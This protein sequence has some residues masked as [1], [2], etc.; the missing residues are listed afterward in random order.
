MRTAASA[1]AMRKVKLDPITIS[2]WISLAV[3]AFFWLI[4]FVF[5]VFTAF[6][7]R[8]EL[9]RGAAWYPPK[10]LFWGNFIDAWNTGKFSTYGVNSLIITLS[11]VPIG[12]FVSALAAFAFSRLR[13]RFQKVLFMIVIMGTM[14]PVQVALGPIFQIMLNA[15]LLST[16]IGILLPYIAFGIPYHV[17]LFNNFFKSIPRELDEAALIDG[18]SKFGLLWRIIIPLSLPIMAAVFILDFVSTWNEFAIALVILQSADAWTVPLG[19][20]AF[21]GQFSSNYGALNASIVLS[22]IPVVIVYLLFQRYFVSGLTAGAV[23]G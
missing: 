1:A 22:I 14:I 8:P 16:Y 5:I 2:L 13:F 9:I 15:K 18:C 21:R 4:P 11:K 17:F 3:G 7:S 19:L 10:D 12:M 6:K 20:M 23:K